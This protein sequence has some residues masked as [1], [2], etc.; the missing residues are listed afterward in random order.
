MERVDVIIVNWN[1][2]DQLRR[3]IASL[4]REIS[5]VER[6]IIVD[7]AS[8]D[9]S[10]AGI[11]DMG[12]PVIIVRNGENRGFAAACNQG[13]R[14]STMEFILFLNPDTALFDNSLSI[15][16]R[17]MGD[18]ETVGIT[19]IQLVDDSGIVAR[20]CSRQIGPLAFIGNSFGLNRLLPNLFRSHM[21]DEWDHGN[22][23]FVDHVMGAFYLIRRELFERL[24]GFDE[25]FF[26]YYEDIDLSKRVL[27]LGLRI[28]YLS[29]AQLYHKGGGTSSQ[30]KARR[31][32]YSIRSKLYYSRKNFG[33]FASSLTFLATL[34][35][36]PIVRVSWSICKLNGNEFFNTVKAFLLV[37]VNV[38]NILKAPI[39]GK[40]SG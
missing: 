17:H 39:P 30:I 27:D 29:T 28:S 24:G 25:N 26:V 34:V 31:L 32:Y 5:L 12:L 20:S 35:V 13:A 1:A 18:D 6:I 7:N 9:G 23:R 22:S 8:I 38:P 37:W 33:P 36:E 10:L 2:G 21:M 14:L 40:H 16:I 4:G 11:E 15:P 3:C 19:G